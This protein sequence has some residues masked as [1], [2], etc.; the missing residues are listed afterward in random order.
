MSLYRHHA[1]MC[2]FW[3]G[4]RDGKRCT[5]LS[6]DN[7]SEWM[8]SSL[9]AVYLNNQRSFFS[10]L[11]TDFPTAIG[12]SIS[13]GKLFRVRGVRATAHTCR[14]NVHTCDDWDS[15]YR[16]TLSDD[17]GTHPHTP[18]FRIPP[19]VIFSFYRSPL[20]LTDFRPGSAHAV[21]ARGWRLKHLQWTMRH[22][23]FPLQLPLLFSRPP[24]Q[25]K[26]STL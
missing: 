23:A 22:A 4:D 24:S 1:H 9:V 19:S 26:T 6:H 7:S 15:R 12:V 11:L 5:I 16:Y 14:Y 2:V 21:P 20:N 10:V 8:T 25:N 3:W 18:F 17:C 13:I